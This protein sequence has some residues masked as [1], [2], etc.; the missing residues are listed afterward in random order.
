MKKQLYLF[1]ISDNFVGQVKLPYGT[2]LVWSYCAQDDTIKSNYELGGWMYYRDEIDRILSKVENPSI[3]GFSNFVWNTSMNYE[4]AKKIKEK[5]PNCLIVF[6]GQGTPKLDRVSNFFIEHPYIDIAVH[7]EG[8]ITFKEILLEN[9]KGKPDFKNVLGCS[10]RESDLSAHTTL[11]RP[12]IKD[13]DS[14]PSPYLNGMFDV[15]IKNKDHDYKFEACIESVRGCPYQCTFCEIGDKY[16]QKLAKQSNEKIYKELDWISKNKIEFFY[17]ADSNFGLF[18]EHLDQVRYVTDLKKKTGYPDNFRIDWA[19]SK[20]DKVIELAEILT[21]AKM[22]KGIT[23]ALQSMNPEVLKATKRKNVDDGKLKEFIDLYKDKKLISYIELILG[24]PMET[25]QSFKDGLFQLLDLGYNDYVDIHPM[26]AL[27]NTP[28][29]DQE[30][31]KKYEIDIVE[32]TP[33]FYHHENVDLVKNE[34]EYMV[35]GSKTM[36][37]EQ[38]IEASMWRWL[39]MFGYSLGH[40]KYIA[41][42]IKTV[43]NVSYK[44]FYEKFYTYMVDNPNSFM[45]KEY[46]ITKDTLGK[47]LRKETLWGRAIDL[48]GNFY[49]YFEEATALEVALNR[50][51][52][53]DSIRGFLN[54]FNLSE[55]VENDILEFQS[56]IIK[57]PFEK[58]PIKKKFNHN[59]KDVLFNNKK[60]TNS[61]YTYQFD[62][63]N[64]NNDVRDWGTKAIWWG[65]RNKG[66]ETVVYEK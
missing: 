58:Y 30:Y 46:L 52:F 51:E 66:F 23:I 47:V 1:E 13:I 20:A 19:K 25:V 26:T 9:L 40:L 36:T 39:F 65:R 2:G 28:F 24:L 63:E 4:L 14:L 45:G 5:Y 61:G 32:T 62:S 7:G 37:R 3:V 17:N 12:R 60:L 29:F 31:I 56:M 34:S 27:P 55:K 18:P 43:K 57:N 64:Y 15:L 16:F 49:W 11:S 44:E 53:L 6:G 35:V 50:D 59:I 42:F 10:V 48:T 41:K 21:N 54:Q 8:E 22:M 38:Y 33:A